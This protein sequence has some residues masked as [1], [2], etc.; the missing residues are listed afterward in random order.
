MSPFISKFIHKAALT[1]LFAAA[2]WST[3]GFAGVVSWEDRLIAANFAYEN[4]RYMEADKYLIS[5]YEEAKLYGKLDT[6]MAKS[7]ANLAAA[8]AENGKFDKAEDLFLRGLFIL[9]KA[10]GTVKTDITGYVSDL[11]SF[12]RAKA[13]FLRD[14]ATVDK[15]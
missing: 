8:F 14:M 12:Y 13:V 3:A 5:A 10:P 11:A 4:G 2:L 1:G 9:K 6:G 7:H 15:N